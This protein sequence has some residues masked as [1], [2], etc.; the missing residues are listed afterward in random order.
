ML[1]V[2]RHEYHVW[3]TRESYFGN[4]AKPI[5]VRHLN[6]EEHKV[7]TVLANPGNCFTAAGTLCNDL[8]IVTLAK[9]SRAASAREWLVIG[10][11][12]FND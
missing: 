1:I 10:H 2:R 6:V 12:D 5:D 8:H 7:G 3:H 9:K 11:Q 4:H